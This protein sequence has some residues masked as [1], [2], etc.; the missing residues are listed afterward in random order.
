MAERQMERRLAIGLILRIQEC[1]PQ[2]IRAMSGRWEYSCS[3]SVPTE[4]FCTSRI[5]LVEC[6][7]LGL[8]RKERRA[9]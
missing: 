8:D 2:A 1:L 4:L 7:P 3:D 5:A 6:A 9:Q